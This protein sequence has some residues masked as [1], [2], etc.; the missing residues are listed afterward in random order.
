MEEFRCHNCN[1]L[2]YKATIGLDVEIICP[3]CRRINYPARAM[4]SDTGLRGMAFQN[5][6]IDHNCPRCHRLLLRS[7]G[8][9]E[10]ET[11]CRSCTKDSN[12]PCLTLYNTKEMRL[13][14][15]PTENTEEAIK[16]RQS[17]AK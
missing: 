9:G 10:L 17:I 4:D 14:N 6:A 12:K 11:T 7:I 16:I 13:G 3:R 8:D 15:I 2:L 1:A 5:K